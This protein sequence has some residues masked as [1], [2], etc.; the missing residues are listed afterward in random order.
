LRQEYAAILL[1]ICAG[2]LAVVGVAT[3]GNCRESAAV[4]LI[5]G[6]GVGSTGAAFL[7]LGRRRRP[8]VAL[9]IA[10]VIGGAIT[11]VLLAIGVGRWVGNCTA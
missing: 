6:S 10:L 8:S 9:F 4:W 2:V 3:S 5:T 7:S 1:W 11:G